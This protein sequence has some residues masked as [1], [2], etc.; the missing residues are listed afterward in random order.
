MGSSELLT[1]FLSYVLFYDCVTTIAEAQSEWG[2]RVEGWQSLSMRRRAIRDCEHARQV[3]HF[4]SVCA[5]ADPS[6][7]CACA[8]RG[9]SSCSATSPPCQ[10]L[11]HRVR[12]KSEYWEWR[13]L[14]ESWAF[15]F[16]SDK[17]AISRQEE[18]SARSKMSSEKESM[19]ELD[20][21]VEQ[22]M[23]CKQLTENQ[24]RNT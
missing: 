21:W 8:D 11:P 15:G 20:G 19:K 12:E 22:L 3:R 23:E 14:W 6:C 5:C 17:F 24:V 13:R 16:F 18:L 4:W 10:P 7:V 9:S 1:V 2:A